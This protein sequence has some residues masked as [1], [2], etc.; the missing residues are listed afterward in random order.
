MKMWK[1]YKDIDRQWTI[2]KAH[3]ISAQ[4]SLNECWYLVILPWC[5]LS[6]THILDVVYTQNILEAFYTVDVAKINLYITW[7]FLRIIKLVR[8]DL[9]VTPFF[10]YLQIPRDRVFMTSGSPTFVVPN[11]F[12]S[13]QYLCIE[14]AVISCLPEC[15]H[16]IFYIK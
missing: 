4:M 8:L 1:V 11:H 10:P 6:K 12:T 13:L 3:E 7:Y 15:S 2:R 16:V 5:L 14:S 9:I